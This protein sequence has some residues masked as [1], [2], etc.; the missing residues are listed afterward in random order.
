MA[1]CVGCAV[2]VP[3]A[4][5]GLVREPPAPGQ[6]QAQAGCAPIPTVDSPKDCTA[7]TPSSRRAFIFDSYSVTADSKHAHN[8]RYEV[9]KVKSALGSEHYS[10][11][12]DEGPHGYARPTLSAFVAMAKAKPGVIFITS[13]GIAPGG[14]GVYRDCERESRDILRYG[15]ADPVLA[16]PKRDAPVCSK[17]Q[18][19]L[20]VQ[21]ETSPQQEIEDYKAYIKAG[22]S[23]DWFEALSVHEEHTTGSLLLTE[24]G[25]VHFFGRLH[26]PLV[27][28][29]ACHSAAL[30]KAFAAYSYVGYTAT[31]CDLEDEI[32]IPAVMDRLTGKV[33]IDLRTTTGAFKAGGFKSP[34]IQLGY[35]RPVV[36]AG[37]AGGTAGGRLDSERRVHGSVAFD[38]QMDA[39]H[40]T[41]VVT[42][43][44]CGMGNVP[45]S[46]T[47]WNK[48]DT[49]MSFSVNVPDT[50]P[51][52][53][54][55]LTVH[56]ELA[57]TPPRIRQPAVERKPIPITRHRGGA[58]RQ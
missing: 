30:A 4:V 45:V 2:F 10:V 38:A 5:A 40:T 47:A 53:T 25:I 58:K 52:G 8:N 29:D 12:E 37:R 26:T 1:A 19:G 31:A 51:G 57:V 18:A 54:L 14:R 24:A 16:L 27:I 21:P 44:G 46:D 22:Y 34:V 39:A 28:D 49:Q 17:E 42:A 50:A 32:D 7:L 43:S 20:G 35:V 15:R 13:H 48:N 11:T 9:G 55:T 36:L 3:N 33:G 41:G 56:H 23:P 6:D